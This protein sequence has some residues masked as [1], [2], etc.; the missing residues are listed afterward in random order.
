MVMFKILD[1]YIIKSFILSIFYG[2][3]AFTLL[4][5]IIDLMENLDDF[6]DNN[7]GTFIILEYY[8]VFTP[9]ILKLM[10]PVAVLFGGLFTAGKM[11]S[12]NELTAIKSSGVSIYRFMFPFIMVCVVISGLIFYFGGF[13]VPNANVRKT[14]IEAEY[15]KKNESSAISNLFFQDPP[16]RIINMFYFNPEKLEAYKTGIQTYDTL[17]SI[18][19]TQRIEAERLVFNPKKGTWT[20]FNGTVRKFSELNE[21][22][23]SFAEMEIT[24]LKFTP[25]DLQVIQQRLEILSNVQLKKLIDDTKNAG[26]DSQRVEIEYYSRFSF[27]F[28]AIIIIIFGLPI[29]T[30]KRRTGIA[31]QFGI[32]ILVTFIY[33]SMMQIVTALGKNGSLEPLIT[34]WLVNIVF[35]SAA[36]FN[37]F[38]IK[39]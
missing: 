1:R 14:Q 10:T 28:T 32:N 9:E 17:N 18:K 22:F 13:V 24:G 27:P 33:L 34:A 39:G 37:L 19:M 30:V 12:N 16:N 3:M 6:I 8:L 15:L 29:S 35:F 5:V 2:L 20:A 31:L 38:R 11:S 7:V 26:Y 23:T 36:M 4:F 25:D 21:N